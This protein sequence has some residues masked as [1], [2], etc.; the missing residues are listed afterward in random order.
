MVHVTAH[1][2]LAVWEM[3]RGE[4]SG[5]FWIGLLG[6]TAGL[7]APLIGALAA[8]AALTGSLLYEHS[9]VQSGQAVPLA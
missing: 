4:Y 9:Y 3:T 1:A 8:I 2:R 7:L 5:F 6:L